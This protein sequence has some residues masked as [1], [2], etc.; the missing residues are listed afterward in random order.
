MSKKYGIKIVKILFNEGKSLIREEGNIL[1]ISEDKKLVLSIIDKLK[2]N[3]VK[4]NGIREDVEYELTP[5]I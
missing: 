5:R 2:E 1:D 4:M 3:Y